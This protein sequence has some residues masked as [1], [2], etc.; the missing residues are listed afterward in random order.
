MNYQDKAIT[1]LN[2]LVNEI[3]LVSQNLLKND[4]ERIDHLTLFLKSKKYEEDKAAY[5]SFIRN[6]EESLVLL[7]SFLDL[8]EKIIAHI[9]LLE[10]SGHQSGPFKDIINRYQFIEER[11]HKIKKLR[12]KQIKL[13]NR[14]SSHKRFYTRMFSFNLLRSL[15]EFLLARRINNEYIIMRSIIFIS[16]RNKEKIESI[17]KMV[18]KEEGRRK[19]YT[20]VSTALWFFPLGGN[21]LRILSSTIFSWLNESS[22]NYKKLLESLNED[23]E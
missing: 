4:I 2:I 19:I 11:F 6:T 5:N 10:P 1:Q 9:L 21:T 12:S 18:I 16:I 8:Y 14:M 20:T 15:N 7:E 17:Q 3:N 13:L 23:K 22:K